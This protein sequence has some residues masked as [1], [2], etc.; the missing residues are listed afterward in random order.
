MAL[1]ASVFFLVAVDDSIVKSVSA[2][3]FNIRAG[4]ERLPEMYT[5]IA[6]IFALSM[7]LL[8][9]LTPKVARQRLLFAI[10]AVLTAVLLVN[11][12]VLAMVERGAPGYLSDSGF[13]PFLFVSSELVRSMANFQIWIVAGGICYTSRA[14]VLFP[15]LAATTT[16]GD[17]VGGF[18]VR[19]L[20]GLLLSFQ[21]YALAALI[22]IAVML[23]MRPLV[24]RYFVTAREEDAVSLAENIRYFARS[25]YLKLLF[26][27]SITLFALYTAIHYG[28]NV[29]ARQHY[30]S[31]GDIT[32]FFGL[33]YGS[34][35][36]ATLVGTSILLRYILRVLG[37]GNIYLWVC[38]VHAAIALS[39]MAVFQ[40]IL[41][42]GAAAVIFASNLLNFFLLDTVIAPTYQVL[43]KRVPQRNRD[44]TRI[45][46]EG[47]F[48]LLGGLVGAG[49]TALH[50]REFLSLGELFLLLT[51]I[52]GAMIVAGWHL[53]RSYTEVLISAVREQNFAVDDQESIESMRLVVAEST[54]FPRSLLMHR[55]DG[56]REMGIEIL[57]QNPAAAAEVCP[58]LIAHEN[59][60]IRAAALDAFGID[61][62]SGSDGAILALPLLDDDDAEVRLSSARFLARVVE[63]T[64]TT[65][66]N[67][68]TDAITAQLR[69]KIVEAV[70]PRLG[71]AGSAR[72]QSEFLVILEM[73]E[74]STSASRRRSL[75]SELLEAEEMEEI[76]AGIQTASRVGAED[77]YARILGY[78]QH[79]QAAVRE[80][81]IVGVGGTVSDRQETFEA[82]LAS[83][84][85]PDP[86]VVEAAVTVLGQC[87]LSPPH[88]ERVMEALDT[89]PPKEWEGL[90]GAMAVQEDQDLL[91]QLME[92][93]R[94]RLLEANRYLVAVGTLKREAPGSATELLGDQLELQ[95]TAVQS[96]VTRLLGDLGDAEV[97]DDLVERL[98][99]EDEEAREHAIELLENI[100]DRSL[101]EFL[102]P[103][104][105]DDEERERL[106]GE[107]CGWRD[108]TTESALTLTMESP[109]TWTQLAAAWTAVSLG[110]RD[111]LSALPDELAGPVE[112]IA[113][114]TE[115]KRGDADMATQDQPLTSME[116]IMF[117]KE[118]SF[119]AALPLEELYHIA[120]SIQEESAREGSVVIKQGTRGGKM[121]I[122]VE[123][124]LEVSRSEPDAEGESQRITVLGENQ[125]FGDMALLDDEPRSASVT[126]LQDCR[127]LSLQRSDLERILR[128]YSSI[129]FNM[130]RILSSRLRDIM[131]A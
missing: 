25:K 114:E 117:L 46:M 71:G 12:V 106:A 107:I 105:A 61:G 10:L 57:R 3:V 28:F 86:D 108:A 75:L 104:L 113:G 97:V 77:S 102:L 44:G 101:M 42:L 19:V 70:T 20:G 109:D 88:R 63:R 122:V 68:G 27:L 59:P 80:A 11:T 84:G 119:F 39:L 90:V 60:R 87:V 110:R 62:Q 130:M 96:G 7:A 82:L 35:G 38:V 67:S 30:A 95:L 85:D 93:C 55:D 121:Y 26:L 116:K 79:P 5:W 22:M 40:G 81:A 31:E 36:I 37:V 4:V 78:L 125:V 21:L 115:A 123:G 64:Q 14:K 1:A 52:S 41:P 74:E 99:A 83:L 34:A 91:P 53:K 128:R 45:I 72:L 32:S 47:G 23:L 120:L 69:D 54:E 9:Y 65:P 2:G 18:L 131:A 124:E 43:I 58:P 13:Y 89:R 66:G 76:L 73:L 118:S 50:A 126:A 24:R 8:A 33:F 29:V 49:L 17:I 15:L 16:L 56:V 112:E 103:T 92:S 94:Q 100:G 51:A 6:C 48:M 127:L 129:A 98:G 111:L